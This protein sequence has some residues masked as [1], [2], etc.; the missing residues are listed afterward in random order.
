MRARISMTLLVAALA[1][2]AWAQPGADG[3][4]AGAVPGP[5]PLHVGLEEGPVEARASGRI[6]GW[7]PGTL[8]PLDNDQQWQVMKGR[9]TLRADAGPAG[10]GGAG[11]RRA[12][13]SA[14]GPRPAQGA[15]VPQALT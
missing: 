12:L 6:T 2:P 14:G 11:H 10:R 1:A 4:A 15:R 3:P 13:V 9:M 7:E 5:P 8:F